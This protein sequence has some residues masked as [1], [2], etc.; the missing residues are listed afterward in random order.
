MTPESFNIADMKEKTGFNVTPDAVDRLSRYRAV[1]LRM[2]AFGFVKVF[3]DNLGDALGVSSSQ[4][5]KDFA[6]FGMKGMKR[7]GYQ[8]GELLE[9]LSSLLGVADSLPIIVIGCGNIGTAI[10]HTYGGKREGVR[11]VAGFDINPKVVAP[12]AELP[13]YDVSDLIPYIEKNHIRVAVLAVPD[14]AASG[15][16]ERLRRSAVQGVLNFTRAPLRGDAQCLVQSID[17]RMEIEKLFC[18]VHL[19]PRSSGKARN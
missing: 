14:E 6:L 8:I 4:V 15:V 19:Q 13:I 12:H 7:G 11:V 2:K 3:S 18:F 5:R 1:L 10:L 16:M 17:I 9:R